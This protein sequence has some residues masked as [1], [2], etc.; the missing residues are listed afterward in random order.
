[1]NFFTGTFSCWPIHVQSEQYSGNL[2]TLKSHGLNNYEAKTLQYFNVK[3]PS[4]EGQIMHEATE[5]E[6]RKTIGDA[7]VCVDYIYLYY[8]KTSSSCYLCGNE[9]ITEKCN[10]FGEFEGNLHLT[11]RSGPSYNYAGFK[12]SISCYAAAEHNLPGC[13]KLSKSIYWRRYMSTQSLYGSDRQNFIQ[14]RHCI[15]IITL[16]I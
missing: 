8:P 4:G 3:C 13:I 5:L 11:F 14:V 16:M 10:N 7:K 1:M 9:T 6:P 15:S 2:F 12:F